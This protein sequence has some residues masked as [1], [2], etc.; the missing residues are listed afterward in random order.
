[1][2]TADHLVILRE[3]LRHI[4]E[5][6][7]I[8]AV[9]LVGF[10]TG[11]DLWLEFAC[12]GRDSALPVVGLIALD[13]NISFETCWVT[14]ILAQLSTDTP[15]QVIEKLQTLSAGTRTLNEWLNVH[16]YLVRLLQKFEGNLEV[17]TQ[18]AAEIVQRFEGAGLEEFARRFRGATSAI[19]CVRLVF[20][21]AGVSNP[22]AEAIASVKLANLDSGFLGEAY[23]ED[24]IV[25]EDDSDH[26]E[27]LSP[28]LLKR[29]IDPILQR[30]TVAAR[31]S[32]PEAHS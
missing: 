16:E 19:P 30:L 2:R 4:V 32:S 1:V 10:S 14:R 24:S 5:H 13:A 21:G 7:N 11:A 27:L 12:R 28:Q 17:L 23:S 18:F 31:K 25:V 20:S 29:Y 22:E 9:I 6:E 3:W 8:K 26:F 15:A